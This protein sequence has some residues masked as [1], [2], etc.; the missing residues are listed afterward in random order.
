MTARDRKRPTFTEDEIETR[1]AA[2]RRGA[3]SSAM[4]GMPL[5]PANADLREALATGELTHAQFLD[6]IAERIEARPSAKA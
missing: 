5:D 3:H 2:M 4:E 1:R 6:R